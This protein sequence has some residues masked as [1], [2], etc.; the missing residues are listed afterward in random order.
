MLQTHHLPLVGRSG[1][2]PRVSPEFL[3]VPDSDDINKYKLFLLAPLPGPN[4]DPGQDDGRNDPDNKI[5]CW[6]RTWFR[7][8]FYESDN[9]C[10]DYNDGQY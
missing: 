4:R 5:G 6:E 7:H 9:T 3:S 8:Y 1:Y 2:Q 10:D